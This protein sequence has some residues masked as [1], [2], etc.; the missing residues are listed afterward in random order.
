M[1]ITI[2]PFEASDI[3]AI[4]A[5]YGEHV[6]SG[7]GSYELQAPSVEEMRGRFDKLVNGNFPIRIACE[8]DGTVVGYAYAGPYH[9]R[10]G[11]RFTVEDSVYIA[12]DHMGKG[13]GN[14]LLL[15]LIHVTQAGPW[16]QMIAVIGDSANNKASVALHKRHGFE[17][18]GT[19]KDTGWKGEAWRDTAIMQ[20]ALSEGGITAPSDKVG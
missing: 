2:R 10:P 9:G 11:W 13:I 8:A 7:F 16:R 4:A 1:A 19:L 5:I 15:D 3:D 17:M 18:I 20:L 12:A 6:R 14:A